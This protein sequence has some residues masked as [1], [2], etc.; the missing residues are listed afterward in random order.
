ME[1]L[2][3]MVAEILMAGAIFYSILGYAKGERSAEKS[4]QFL[5]DGLTVSIVWPVYVLSTCLFS[6]EEIK[7]LSEKRGK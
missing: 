2:Y 5:L 6:E 4:F 7:Q 1:T 3:F